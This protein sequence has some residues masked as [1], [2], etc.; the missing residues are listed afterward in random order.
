MDDFEL[1]GGIADVEVIAVNLSIREHTQLK[2]QFGGRRWRK[3]VAQVRFPNGEV[4]K[5]ELHWYEAHGV[6]RRK[7]KVKRR[8]D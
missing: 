4:H 8:L 5:A 6:G 7:M 3:G 2:A 1:V